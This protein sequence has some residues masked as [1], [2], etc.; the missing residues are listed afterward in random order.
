MVAYGS[1]NPMNAPM[2]QKLLGSGP[3]PPSS[4]VPTAT[5]TSRYFIDETDRHDILFGILKTWI[6]CPLLAI[7]KDTSTIGL[8]DLR[9]L[10]AGIVSCLA[11][12]NTSACVRHAAGECLRMLLDAGFVHSWDGTT[13]DWRQG[14]GV[15]SDSSMFVFWRTTSQ[16]MSLISKVLV[17]PSRSSTLINMSMNNNNNNN[18]SNLGGGGKYE[19]LTTRSLTISVLELLKDLLKSRNQFLRRRVDMAAVGSGVPERSSA[20]THLEIAFLVLLCTPD[21]EVIAQTVACIG[22][23]VDEVELTDESNLQLQ[24]LAAAAAAAAAAASRAGSVDSAAVVGAPTGDMEGMPSA[25]AGRPTSTRAGTISSASFIFPDVQPY[26]PHHLS[27]VEN[28]GVYRELR[29]LYEGTL[30]IAGQ[31]VMQK[32]IRKILRK[33]ERAS[34]GTIGAWEE[35]YRRWRLISSSANLSEDRGERQ[36]YTGFLCALGGV[37]LKSSMIV[38][39]QQM[40]MAMGVANMGAMGAMGAGVMGTLRSSSQTQASSFVYQNMPPAIPDGMSEMQQQMMMRP[41]LQNAR[42]TMEKFVSD[43]V[44]LMVCDN[45]VIREYVKDFLGN[46][47]TGGL[48]DILFTFCENAVMRLLSSD[49]SP[50]AANADRNIFFVDS[51]ISVLKMNMDRS[52]TEDSL[53]IQEEDFTSMTGS[54][55]LGSLILSFVQFINAIVPTPSNVQTIL[56]MKVK[57]C[58]LTELVVIQR[59]KISLRQDIRF[60]NRMLD[61]LIQWNSEASSIQDFDGEGANQKLTRDID[62]ASMKALVSVLVG[63]PLQPSTEDVVRMQAEASIAQKDE[64]NEAYET[65][66]Q[67]KG[68]Q[69]YKYLNFFLKVLQNIKIKEVGVFCFV[70]N[71]FFFFLTFTGCQLC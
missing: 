45:V 43:L 1:R 17:D 16:V 68:K 13:P 20:T 8:E 56:R 7:A 22:H 14:H 36:N 40:Q 51:F 28:I 46:D 24:Q 49:P 41:T 65:T 67:F 70:F 5:S 39:Q 23:L 18:N 55:D 4:T 35:V 32:K 11:D 48:F 26:T 66:N 10:F 53:M 21:T 59:E 64:D 61:V 63:L 37:C 34:A 57:I 62:L 2:K 9:N 38:F 54:F 69:F 12:L 71:V 30:V 58:Q 25:D 27:V 31:K 33:T 50:V 47:I 29:K 19:D 3:K 42:A 60:R 52:T 44:N 15:V 6:K